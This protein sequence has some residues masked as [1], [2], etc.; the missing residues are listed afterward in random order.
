MPS[1]AGAAGSGS[2]SRAAS[3]ST[4]SELSSVGELSEAG[5]PKNAQRLP[6]SPTCRTAEAPDGPS[7][8]AGSGRSPL[9]GNRWCAENGKH[10][11]N[12][13]N[14]PNFPAVGTS[15]RGLATRL[16]SRQHVVELARVARVREWLPFGAPRLQLC[17]E[18][19]VALW[20]GKAVRLGSLGGFVC[21]SRSL[22]Q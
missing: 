7:P 15:D 21:R 6:P 14:L 12:E 17:D 20:R 8:S 22:R 13:R 16:E 18:F 10:W 4:L 9:F 2:P 19:V 11:A 5:R 1:R 3:V